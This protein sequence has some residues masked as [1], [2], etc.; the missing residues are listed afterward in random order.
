MQPRGMQAFT[1]HLLTHICRHFGK[2]AAQ[3]R[4]AARR[5]SHSLCQPVVTM[6]R[7]EPAMKQMRQVLLADDN[8]VDADPARRASAGGGSQNREISVE[9]YPLFTGSSE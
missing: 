1:E 2:A 8:P 5:L 7:G 4:M 3:L 6:R 9:S